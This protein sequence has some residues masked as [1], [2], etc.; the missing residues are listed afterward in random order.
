MTGHDPNTSTALVR[1]SW[2][3]WHGSIC[4]LFVCTGPELA[5][6]MRHG[7]VYVGDELGKYSEI[8]VPLNDE[9]VSVLTVD[10]ALIARLVAAAGGVTIVG[11]NPIQRLRDDGLWRGAADFSPPNPNALLADEYDADDVGRGNALS[12]LL[13][14]ATL[15][16]ECENPSD[17]WFEERDGEMVLCYLDGGDA[18]YPAL[19]FARWQGEDRP[20][21]PTLRVHLPPALTSQALAL[22]SAAHQAA[23]LDTV[24]SAPAAWRPLAAELGSPSVRGTPKRAEDEDEDEDEYE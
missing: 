23:Y 12:A 20:D 17:E 22:D 5:T 24:W 8:T 19:M 3:S 6:L 18:Y 2:D 21:N 16:D 9:T 15:T 13:M 14:A 10:Q 11:L 4:G 1:L 7:S